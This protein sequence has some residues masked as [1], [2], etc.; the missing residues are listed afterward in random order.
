MLELLADA[1]VVVH[2]YRPDALEGLGLGAD[3]RADVR[4]GLV[5]VSLDAYGWSGPWAGRRGFDSLVQM[6]SG[7]AEAGMEAAG[8]D[9]PVSL[10]VQ[11]LDQATGYLLA[12]AALT[13]LA[14]GPGTAGA[15]GGAPRWPAWRACWS[16]P[17]RSDP[18]VPGIDPA[19]P[20]PGDAGGG[21]AWGDARRL[22]PPL[23]V[24][25]SPLRWDRPAGPLG[26]VRRPGGRPADPPRGG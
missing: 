25:G 11:A 9:H 21:T 19:A 6:S 15:A 8:A 5:D 3:L 13:G 4:P 7:I 20:G 23:E 24:A 1:D 16:T 22:P 26:A 2:G 18:G 12:A 17:G 10:P 14:R